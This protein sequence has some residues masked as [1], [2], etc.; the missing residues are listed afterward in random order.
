MDSASIKEL[1][2]DNY[3]LMKYSDALISDYSSA[4]Y[5]FLLLDR[6]LAFVLDDIDTYSVGFLVDNFEDFLPGEKLYN[7]ERHGTHGIIENITAAEGL[8][9]FVSHQIDCNI[10]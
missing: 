10:I 6:P 2:I 7:I 5:S 8:K 1:N 9:C 3:R 4:A